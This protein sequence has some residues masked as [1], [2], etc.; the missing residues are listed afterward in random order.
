[1][2]KVCLLIIYNHRYDDNIGKLEKIYAGRFDHIMHIVPFYTGTKENVIPV[3]EC[4][5]RFQG[6]IAQAWDKFRGDYEQYLFIADDMILHPGMNQE[7]YREFFNVEKDEAFITWTKPIGKLEGWGFGRRFMDP[8]PVLEWYNGTNW[9]NE[10]ISADQAFEIAKTRGCDRQDFT[11]PLKIV[12]KNRGNVRVY[13]RLFVLFF[14][15]LLLGAQK[16]PYPIWGGYSD[17]LIIPGERMKDVAH[18]MGVFAGM[19][20]YVEIAI[21]TAVN[22]MCKKV[23]EQTDIEGKINLI[24]NV[25]EKKNLAKKYDGQY[26]T[27]M[28]KWDPSWVLMHPVKL[29]GWDV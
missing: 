3:Y 6:Y 24:W 26:N 9:K 19:N 23:K 20:L 5:F 4:S 10:I 22:L 29:S 14:K 12:W 21:P 7:N 8:L 2:N 1:M 27:L 15:I 11:I 13:P 18:M 25:E 16:S 17:V 28:E